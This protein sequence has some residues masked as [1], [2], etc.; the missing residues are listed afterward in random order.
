MSRPLVDDPRDDVVVETQGQAEGVEAGP[1]VG[2]GGRHPDVRGAAPE[3]RHRI[4]SR[5]QAELRG[6][7]VR[8]DGDRDR[9]WAR[10]DRPLR[11]LEPVAGHRADHGRAGGQPTVRAR[12]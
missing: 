1:E 9:A 10:R 8:V 6:R 5:R 7:G 3:R 11:V 2:A 12:S 4:V